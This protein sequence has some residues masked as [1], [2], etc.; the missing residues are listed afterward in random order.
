VENPVGH[1]QRDLAVPLLTDAAVADTT[2]DVQAA[3]AAAR[4]W[5]LEVNAAGAQRDLRHPDERL[6]AE[7]GLGSPATHPMSRGVQARTTVPD[8]V[9]LVRRR[10]RRWVGTRSRF[11]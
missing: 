9:H 11:G 7:R 3:H 10:P 1:A 4:A 8:T 5:D 2:L 6:I